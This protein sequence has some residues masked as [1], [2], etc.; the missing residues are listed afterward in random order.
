QLHHRTLLPSVTSPALNPQIP[1]DDG[2]AVQ[3]TL[4]G[5]EAPDG[6]PRRAGLSSFGVGGANVHLVVDEGPPSPAGETAA[7]PP[8]PQ[9]V[10]V[11]A[12]SAEALRLQAKAL[13][14][15]LD[16]APRDAPLTD[17]AYTLNATRRA[18]EHRAAW[19]VDDLA[20]LREHLGR[21]AAG[22]A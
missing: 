20:A 15:W 5:W 10:T 11:S 14:D 17:V 21:L 13:G 7:P 1:F 9:L 4:E 6:L 22:E 19:V 2:F 8:G 12:R 3:R 18:F 16:D